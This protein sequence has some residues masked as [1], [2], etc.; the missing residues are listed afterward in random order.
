MKN[1]TAALNALTGTCRK[2]SSMVIALGNPVDG[3]FRF[4]TTMDLAGSALGG[5]E[6]DLPDAAKCANDQIRQTTVI[7]AMSTPSGP[8]K[9]LIC[10]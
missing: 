8:E 6:P 10:F 9:L 1:P 7:D 2:G 3:W 5:S 4:H